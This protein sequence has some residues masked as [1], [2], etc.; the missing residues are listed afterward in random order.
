M[1]EHNKTL[2]YCVNPLD[3]IH[4]YYNC[5]NFNCWIKWGL[6]HDLF[7]SKKNLSLFYPLNERLFLGENVSP[8]Y[9][10]LLLINKG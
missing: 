1:Y 3:F 6:K 2:Y 4:N 5:T 9:I 7:F 10:T 8:V